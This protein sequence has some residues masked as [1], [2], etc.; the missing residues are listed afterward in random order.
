MFKSSTKAIRLSGH[1]FNPANP[2]GSIRGLSL[3]EVVISLG[4]LAVIAG[5]TVGVTF[6]VRSMSEQTVY[7]NT[8]L[9]FAQGYLEQL[10]SLDY[11]TLLSAAGSGSVPLELINASG[12]TITDEGGGEMANGD[13]ARETVFLDE[14]AA[15]SPIQP[16][17]F[18]FRPVLTSL[19]A[20]TG[21]TAAGVELTLVFQ[22]TYNFGVTRTFNGTLRSVRSSV[23]T[24]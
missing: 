23:P 9:T 8:A 5:G 24:Y 1:K 10:R 12:V 20:S 6:Q 22:T 14:N 19:A 2:L 17:T 16:M 7:E 13:W 11:N 21:G 18:R 3:V 15:G 4:I